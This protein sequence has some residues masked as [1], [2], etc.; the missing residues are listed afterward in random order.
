MMTVYFTAE[1]TTKGGREGHVK[2]NDLIID[3]DLAMP[4]PNQASTA[5]N[6]EQLFAAGYSACY[7][8]ALHLAAQRQRLKIESAV[9]GKVSL[10]K[11]ESDNGYKIGVV[12]EVEIQGVSQEQAEELTH[13]A[14]Q[15]CPY[16][17]ATRGNIDVQIITTAM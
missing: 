10:L 6:P 4:K 16:S 3:L 17:K 5:T 2:S 13:A 12:L 8:S 7:D 1:A 9:T 11:D 14:H 15:V